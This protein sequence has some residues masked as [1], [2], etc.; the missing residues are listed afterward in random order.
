MFSL[1]SSRKYCTAVAMHAGVPVP[2]RIESMLRA[3]WSDLDPEAPAILNVLQGSDAPLIWHKHSSFFDHLREVWAMLCNWE[4]PRDVCRL[5]LLHSAY[6]NSFV[7]MNC[8]DP[9]RDRPVVAALVGDEAEN[10]IYKF[11][12]IDRQELE[13]IVLRE[14]TI[15]KEGYLM[16]HIHTGKPLAV[17]GVEAAAFV[18]ETLADE[19]DQ[20]FGWQSD[21]EAGATEACWPGPV[22]PTL[23]LSR[24]SRLSRALYN[25]EIVDEV[26][27]PPIFECCSAVLDS[28]DEVAARDAYWRAISL[29]GFAPKTSESRKRNETQLAALQESSRRNRFLAEP[30]IVSAQCLL[31]LEQWDEAEA[32]ATRGVRLLCA[33]GTQWDKRMPFNS[34][35]NWARCLA[36]QAAFCEWPTTHGG[37]ESLGATLPRMR[38]RNLNT[39]RSMQG[40]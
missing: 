23:R 24:T 3:R 17:S 32:A 30:H 33:W 27:L 22:L 28:N 13:E 7:S 6:S 1:V 39:D 34:W 21:L 16:R 40:Q 18:T 36:L 37:I 14:R 35:V 4:Q 9:V 8:F 31:H 19:A 25:S 12:S 2:S 20:R 5:G 38:F 15:R 29:S 10:L 26:A 11:C